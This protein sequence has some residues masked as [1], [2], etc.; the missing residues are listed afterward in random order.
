MI[1]TPPA[2]HVR[3]TSL[4][5][6]TALAVLQLAL[7]SFAVAVAEE[8]PPSAVER[9]KVAAAKAAEE[10][11]AAQKTAADKAAAAKASAD[12]AATVQANAEK[13]A[14]EKMAADQAAA[15]AAKVAAEK[16]AAAK[17]AADSAAAAKAAADSAAAEKAAADKALAEKDA[18][19]KAAAEKVVAEVAY[20][21]KIAAEKIARE[22]VDAENAAGQAATAARAAA[23]Q[24]AAAQAAA[25]KAAAEK[26]AAVAAGTGTPEL[27]KALEEKTAAA[28][29]AAEKVAA[30]KTAADAAAA[31]SEAAQKAVAEK[32]AALPA[33]RDQAAA[34][35]A[36]ALGGLTPLA[37]SAWDYAKARHLLV[38][39]GFGGTPD[40]VK[41]LHEMGLHEAVNYLVDIYERP[42]ANIELDPLRLENHEPWEN[43]LED[44]E[45]TDLYNRRI[46]RE[47]RQQ[48]ELR[49]WWLRRM[50]ESPRPLQE[51]MSLFWHDHFAV[52]YMKLYL[53]DIL[54]H[55]NELFRTHGCDNYGALLRG[56]VHDTAMI[57]YLDN[58]VNF[59]GSGNENLGRE[60]LELF[61][62]GEG[63]G[64]TEED[65]REAARC[66]T[67]YN[68]DYLTG[69][70]R[71]VA[72]RHDETEKTVFGNKGNWGGDELVDLILQHPATA[73]YVCQKLFVFFAYENPEP[74]TVER[75]AHV[76][77]SG[78]YNMRPMLKNLFLSEQF[79]SERAR[80][81]H[82]KGPIE[83]AVG[84]IRDLGIKNVNY[85]AV[86]SAVIQMGQYLYEPPNVAGW[87]ENRTWINAERILI[88][89]NELANLVEQ[90]NV[91]VVGLLENRGLETP[92]QI[93]DYL[94]TTCLVIRPA[95]EK[96]NELAVFLGA[97]PPAGEWAAQRDQV[98]AK[99]RALLV[100][101]LS[102][103][104]SQLG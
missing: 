91:D 48:A 46:E 35:H 34:T 94:V 83:L 89:Y 61:S 25:E 14:A 69:Q 79:Y 67:G 54:Y 49:Q 90:P 84:T 77:R 88:R 11:A 50:A 15:A 52:Q 41:R 56:I 81:T 99:L 82:I 75:L 80:G 104:E 51:K 98:N 59:K 27:Q 20:E 8:A 66:L 10:A 7:W 65:M 33:A 44:Q 74:E 45:R 72:T 95:D 100:L 103:P 2:S 68:Y 58:Q 71:F 97:L 47:R 87:K 40:E 31:A 92:Q 85:A 28:A 30:A 16:E 57:L 12:G 32:A 64:Y 63:H 24:L 13:A 39:A 101:L 86:D 4:A 6:V 60:I 3:S 70:F 42:V 9:A 55:Q 36:A 18:A 29:A 23:D 96:R 5:L 26:E 22:K 1:T 73:N 76:L 102:T 62:L 93:V 17:A 37:S 43:R 19:A 21:A 78:S 38:R 53:T